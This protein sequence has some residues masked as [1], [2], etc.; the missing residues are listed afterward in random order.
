MIAARCP[1]GFPATRTPADRGDGWVFDVPSPACVLC[2]RSEGGGVG[3]PYK[4]YE[5]VPLPP[6]SIAVPEPAAEPDGNCL[7]CGGIIE[8]GDYTVAV[9]GRGRRHA[10]GSPACHQRDLAEALVTTQPMPP[11]PDACPTCGR[12]VAGGAPYDLPSIRKALM[13]A[14]AAVDTLLV[15][16]RRL[17][18]EAL[19]EPD[20]LT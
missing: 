16:E 8:P 7:R 6:P 10:V 13:D 12:P 15:G 14:L 3:T 11:K 19:E 9:A 4:P 1:H 20:D 18:Q 2:A 5:Y 17:E